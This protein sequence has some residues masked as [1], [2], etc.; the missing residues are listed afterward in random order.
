MREEIQRVIEEKNRY[1]T[2]AKDS[3]QR[4]LQE[5]V[6]AVTRC[7]ELERYFL[8]KVLENMNI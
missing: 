6:D 1:E 3:I 7:S 2:S 4:I 5:K 8:I